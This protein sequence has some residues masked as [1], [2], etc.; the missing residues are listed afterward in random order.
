MVLKWSMSISATVSGVHPAELEQRLGLHAHFV[1]VAAERKRC[2]QRSRSLVV[3]TQQAEH[4]PRLAE[5]MRFV[6]AIAELAREAERLQREREPSGV[7]PLRGVA[8]SGRIASLLRE[9]RL[10]VDELGQQVLVA[11]RGGERHTVGQ[12]ALGFVRAARR[13]GYRTQRIVDVD[14]QRGETELACRLERRQAARRPR[15]P[16]RRAGAGTSPRRRALWSRPRRRREPGTP[17]PLRAGARAT[18]R[19]RSRR[20]DSARECASRAR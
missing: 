2:R 8:V 12:V 1:Q 17:E 11:L 10:V 19:N 16:A 4:R 6:V 18:P 13:Q 15:P 3:T 9:K 20:N 7:F 5:R 14:F